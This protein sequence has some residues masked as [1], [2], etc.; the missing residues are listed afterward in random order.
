MIPVTVRVTVTA[1][2]TRI[3]AIAS[4]FAPSVHNSSAWSG[5]LTIVGTLVG[6]VGGI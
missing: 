2:T 6:F 3:P 1:L 4:L 5:L